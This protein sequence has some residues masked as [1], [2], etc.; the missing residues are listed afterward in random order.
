MKVI[1]FTAIALFIGITSQCQALNSY[2]DTSNYL[3]NEIG[4]KK[5]LYIGKAFSVL[6]D[7]LKIKPVYLVN[8]FTGKDADFG[9]Q[10][11]FEFNT[12]RDFSKAHFIIVNFASVPP[13]DTLFPILYPGVG[14]GHDH[15][16]VINTY[17][18]LIVKNIIIKDYSN[19]DPE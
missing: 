19:D 5:N 4:A 6:L 10:L 17:K 7:S 8:S 11:R 1:I 9:R 14:V 13:Y 2:A 16:V 15:N 12:Q 18:P 3:I